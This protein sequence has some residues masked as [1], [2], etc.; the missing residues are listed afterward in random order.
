MTIHA[1]LHRTLALIAAYA[2]A[3]QALLPF[4]PAAIN[5]GAAL[6]QTFAICSADADANGVAPP[7]SEH[8]SGCPHGA[9]CVMPGCGAAALFPPHSNLAG[10]ALAVAAPAIFPLHFAEVT[11]S[12]GREPQAPRAP[13]LA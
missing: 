9:A 11:P 4:F 1:P 3:L 5:A 13:P 6:A 12:I 10:I 8:D 7:P 2:I